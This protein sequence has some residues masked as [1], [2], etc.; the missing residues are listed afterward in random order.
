[1]PIHSSYCPLHVLQLNRAVRYP[2]LSTGQ[3]HILTDWRR[4]DHDNWKD[5]IL[6][7]YVNNHL[8]WQL[9]KLN[10]L[11]GWNKALLMIKRKHSSF[12]NV[13]ILLCLKITC[14]NCQKIILP[15]CQCS[16]LYFP[17]QSN[18]YHP[19]NNLLLHLLVDDGYWALVVLLLWIAWVRSRR[20]R[21]CIGRRLFLCGNKQ[22]Q[23]ILKILN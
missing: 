7:C 17:F 6:I 1:M 13:P 9:T 10:K 19:L 14:V 18:N 15:F 20:G 22:W 5:W 2:F 4:A 11:R 12:E 23:N 21:R 3:F 8:T 16:T